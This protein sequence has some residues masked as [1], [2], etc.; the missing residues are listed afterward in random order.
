[1]RSGPGEAR[2]ILLHH[3]IG[4]RP[5]KQP[6]LVRTFLNVYMELGSYFVSARTNKRLHHHRIDYSSSKSDCSPLSGEDEE[7]F[8]RCIG[9]NFGKGICLLKIPKRDADLE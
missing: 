6:L 3:I 8:G 9:S 4:A 2:A 5:S 1:V 7:L